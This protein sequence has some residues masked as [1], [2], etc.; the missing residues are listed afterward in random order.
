[1]SNI[2][3]ST[4]DK[5]YKKY[6]LDKYTSGSTAKLR[7]ISI[8]DLLSSVKGD[9][10]LENDIKN[11]KYFDFNEF[12]KIKSK[13]RKQYKKNLEEKIK[14]RLIRKAEKKENKQKRKIKYELKHQ[15]QEE[16]KLYLQLIPPQDEAK[17]N[18]MIHEQLI[19]ER[20]KHRAVVYRKSKEEKHKNKF[21]DISSVFFNDITEY[22]DIYNNLQSV[23]E[24]QQYAFKINVSYGFVFEESMN[25]GEEY[26][27]RVGHAYDNTKLLGEPLLIRNKKDFEKLINI[28]ELLDEAEF[29]SKT[30][31]GGKNSK[32]KALGIYQL[33]VKI[34]LLKDPIGAQVQLPEKI[35]NSKF[36]YSALNTITQEDDK[37]C[38]WRCLAKYKH[39]DVR[40]N[41]L[42]KA[43]K[44]LF[45]KYYE[46]EEVKAKYKDSKILI[47]THKK[48][49][50]L[51]LSEIENI[52][53]FFDISINIYGLQIN[54]NE[55][56]AEKIHINGD[57]KKEKMTIGQYENHFVFIKENIDNLCK[58]FRCE[59]CLKS[60][61]EHRNLIKHQKSECGELYK[62]VFANDIEEFTHDDNIMKKILKFSKSKKS[63]VYPYFAVYDF[64]SIAKDI[65]KKKGKNTVIL[66]KQVPISFSFGTNF[67]SNIIHEVNT[68]TRELIN[69]LVCCM[70]KA[71]EE[72]SKKIM[73]EYYEYI[74]FYCLYKLKMIITETTETDADL[75][76]YK[77]DKKILF[78]FTDDKK[79]FYSQKDL[80]KIK[81]W[82]QF[83]IVGFNNSF[84]DINISK[85]YDF[86]KEFNPTFAIKQGTRYKALSNDKI[87]ILDMMMYNPA[88]TSLDKY[89]KSRETDMIKGH[90]PYKWL[91]SFN[92][93]YEKQLPTYKYF[94]KTKTTIDE[95]EQLS[96][97]WK[98]ENMTNMFD[99]LK[100]YNNLDVKPLIQ[101]VT[102]HK[103]FYYDLGFDMLKDAISLSGLAEKIMFKNSN[104]QKY[105]E[106]PFHTEYVY[107]GANDEFEK[108][109]K[110]YDN[111]VY[112]V[113]EE[114]KNCFYLLR[115]NNVG[116]PSI[117]FH[118]YHEKDVTRISFVIR[119]NKT[120]ILNGEGKLI[121]KI[122]GFDANALY[123]WSL[124]QY[125]PTSTLRH[126]EFIQNK[127][128][129]ELLN[130]T[131]GF[132]E[133]DIEVPNDDDSYNKFVKFSP[134]F[135]R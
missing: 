80:S 99:Y 2:I 101:A 130:T 35:L 67:E 58:V 71:Q 105:D 14:A 57:N 45:Y 44:D 70:Y 28:L 20:N 97:I 47:T 32:V 60:F 69:K 91:T 59:Q 85:D 4:M 92:K 103:S 74:K 30:I 46:N 54:N 116:G 27:Y 1:M 25:N 5:L 127:N 96:S 66:N 122:V 104:E 121:K 109:V 21:E 15:P 8:L 119:K 118:R 110:V 124:S 125:M 39:P 7:K 64:E 77:N 120:Y 113:N 133:V 73:S 51:D 18:E 111:K 9:R 100:Y 90:F 52:E 53:I 11:M 41:K 40:N 95:Y 72:A 81:K 33:F 23:Y 19:E 29:A 123:L 114:N 83:P 86:I 126:E 108:E 49:L 26:T 89:L 13:L 24:A 78:T 38:F 16:E 135:K 12:D 102:K 61:V 43:S 17:H 82:L 55:I 134:I 128:I 94:E 56:L 129:N 37:L 34:Y 93:L 79:K 50:G 107:S 10:V 22:T 48:Y 3:Y 115:D 132:Y 36:V 6:N 76:L 75:V 117:V 63:F 68:D 65:D 84:Y 112:L 62:D 131:F 87:C 42:I 88:G 106:V 98:N 31:E